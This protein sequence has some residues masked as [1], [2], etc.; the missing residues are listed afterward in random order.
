LGTASWEQERAGFGPGMSSACSA[1]LP[2][3]FECLILCGGVFSKCYCLWSVVFLIHTTP[4]R[5]V[6]VEVYITSRNIS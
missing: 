3:A 2:G 5:S 1:P 4:L 6:A